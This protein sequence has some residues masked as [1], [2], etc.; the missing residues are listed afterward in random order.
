MG[1]PIHFPEITDAMLTPLRVLRVLNNSNEG[2]L[3]RPGCPYTDDQKNVLR[4][5]LG[6]AADAPADTGPRTTF[7][8]SDEDRSV[9][10]ERQIAMT[11]EDMRLIESKMSTMDQ[12]DKIAFLKAKP[13]LLEKLIELSEKNRGQ[14]VLGDF[15]KSMYAFIHDELNADQRTALVKKLGK[16]IEQ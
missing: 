6:A 1:E 15:M 16:Y 14:K 4:A 9:I 3:D 7:L 12:K 2:L 10:M 8:D 5:L 11:L 13:G